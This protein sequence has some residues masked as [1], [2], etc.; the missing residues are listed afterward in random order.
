VDAQPSPP[1]AA[2]PQGLR[3]A[4]AALTG[5]GRVAVGALSAVLVTPFALA[6]LGATRFGLWALAGGL[7][8]LLR[9]TDLGLGR[10]LARRVAR[11]RGTSAGRDEADVAA[12]AAARGLTLLLGLGGLALVALLR[13][14]LAGP[15]LGVPPE[16]AA[17]AG[18]VLVG[19]AG[20]A[21]LEGIFA[22]GQAALEGLGRLDRVN[23]IDAV[24]Q[25]LL[26]PWLVLPV[27]WAGGGLEGLVLKNAGTALLA[28]LWTQ[29]E[30]ARI[31]P[32][33]AWARPALVGAASAELLRFGRHVQAVNLA[34]A[35]IDPLAK[36][37]LGGARGLGAVAAYEL[38]ARIAG[39]L[40]GAC[41]AA[42]AGLFPAAALLGAVAPGSER[43]RLVVDL[44]GRARRW[45]DR[46]VLAVW[47]LVAVL[48][49]AFC[50]LWLGGALAAEVAQA[51]Q[52]FIPGWIL[53]LLAL[54]AFLITQAAGT[55]ARSTAAGLCTT[56]VSLGGAF[57][58]RG[59]GLA[60]V[61]LAMSAGLAAGGLWMLAAFAREQG[62]AAS[63]L[64][65][66]RR[67][68]LAVA[69]GALVA[70]GLAG[71]DPVGWTGLLLAGMAG[72]I[73]VLAVLRLS[74]EMADEDWALLGSAGRRL[75]RRR[76]A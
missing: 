70:R 6:Q 64:L 23:V 39:Q 20:V 48:A 76:P 51:V 11:T 53:A 35:L 68:L 32:P 22:P 57:L 19:T 75:A 65:P 24:V 62:L 66:D 12:M 54:P 13:P 46:L 41:M 16:L 3:L 36:A 9:L 34:S 69:L 8:G 58:A 15:R 14:V 37:I 40:G 17:E 52:I 59:W 44:H 60:G 29:R 7:I 31:D 63:A 5:G 47:S 67:A 27:L 2:G 30:L 73:T 56:A 71:P 10:A 55:T 26:S 25:R 28:G 45:M 43:R 18:W 1:A 72:G 38:A 61:A 49:P 74:G 21:A 50:R 33:L 4:A 42:A